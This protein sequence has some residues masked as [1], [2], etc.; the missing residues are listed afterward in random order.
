VNLVID[1]SV[2]LK[3]F[4]NEIGSNEATALMTRGDR[5]IAPDLI[6]PEVSNVTWK[7]VRRGMMTERQ[8]IDAVTRL[9]L[10]L[11]ELTPTGALAARAV[12]IA[13][14][15]DRPAYDCFYLA[16]TERCG[17]ILISADLRLAQRLNG[18]L[19]EEMITDPRTFV[20]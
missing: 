8:Q 16:L 17:G 12:T 7:M 19:W 13:T 18:T 9:P 6:V 5:L 1:A 10:I 11:D 15:L 3:W 14:L 2:A 4:H 20:T